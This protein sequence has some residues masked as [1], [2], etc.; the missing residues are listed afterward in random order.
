MHRAF[1]LA[2]SIDGIERIFG[3]KE[4]GKKEIMEHWRQANLNDDEHR[5]NPNLM[6]SRDFD[7]PFSTP[8]LTACKAAELQGGTIMHGGI[9]DRIQKA[10]LTECYN[11]ADFEVLKMCAKE[12]GLVLSQWETDYHSERVKQILNEDL[13]QAHIYGVNSVPTIVVN[14]KY[15][16]SGAQPYSSLETWFNNQF[17]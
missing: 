15:K 10:H 2:P 9:F 6:V 16:L 3:S 11:I 8:G 17:L 7:Y 12:V 14:G 13:S 5:L 1:A 4:Q